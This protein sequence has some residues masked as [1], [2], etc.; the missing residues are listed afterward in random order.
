MHAFSHVTGGGLAANL[1]RVLPAR[2]HAEV[3]RATWELPPVFR[4]LLDAAWTRPTP[5]GPS[6]WAW[7]CWLS[8][9]S[10]GPWWPH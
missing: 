10:Q 3:D 9:I 8:P 7:G 1:A 4:V 6:T 5:S 2:L